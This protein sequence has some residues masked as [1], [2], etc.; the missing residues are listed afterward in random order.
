MNILQICYSY[1]PSFSGYGKQLQTVNRKYLDKYN[2]NIIILTAYKGED[3]EVSSVKSLFN[4]IRSNKF[5]K[6]HY[7]LFCASLPI[8]MIKNIKNI[9]VI[10]IVKAGPEAAI[11]V[12]ISWVFKK[13]CLV[14]VAQDEVD[15]NIN[16]VSFLRKIRLKILSKANLFIGLSDKIESDIININIPK[17]KIL[18]INNAIDLEQF[19]FYKNK[20]SLRKEVLPNSDDAIVYTFVGAICKRKGIDDILSA[21]KTIVLDKKLIV[22]FIGPNYKDVKNL[23]EKIN[24]INNSSEKISIRLHGA[25]ENAKPYIYCADYLLLPTYSEGMPNVVLEAFACGTPVIVSDIPVCREIVNDSNGLLFKVG[26]ILSLQSVILR[27]MKLS[28]DSTKIEE[29]AVS[30]F[31]SSLIAGKYRDVYTR[32]KNE[33]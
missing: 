23:N 4:Y 20:I 12:F 13:P 11:A 14:K 15:Y 1:P 5:E 25:V 24:S 21:L 30:E 9:D 7:Y 31:S 19:T 2:D 26:D 28:W 32:L 18:R 8:M 17:E 3:T 10:H 22:Y 27:S 6:L 16:N 33:S 29:Y